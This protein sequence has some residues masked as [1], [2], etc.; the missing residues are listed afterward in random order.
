MLTTEHPMQAQIERAVMRNQVR[1]TAFYMKQNGAVGSIM[2]A[3]TE[4]GWTTPIGGD[5]YRM[6]QNGTERRGNVWDAPSVYGKA[7]PAN[8][9]RYAAMRAAGIL[10][11]A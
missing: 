5:E 11:T 3:L 7:G 2:R 9:A 4:A 10:P 6:A 1:E 8:R